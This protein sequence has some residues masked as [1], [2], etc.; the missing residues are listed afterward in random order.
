MSREG[1]G[2]GVM[3]LAGITFN[4]VGALLRAG[5]AA[6]SAAG[7]LSVSAR[8]LKDELVNGAKAKAEGEELTSEY[9]EIA[10]R[11]EPEA[12]RQ[13]SLMHQ[14]AAVWLLACSSAIFISLAISV[15]FGYLFAV[16]AIFP[17][18]ATYLM[19]ARRAWLSHIASSSADSALKFNEFLGKY[20][21]FGWA[22]RLFVAGD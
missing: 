20:G 6:R 1:K 14:Q 18:V 2:P 5:R 4:P 16:P 19:A 21:I 13:I 7:E 9:I 22:G 8:Y 10:A 11:V 15:A 3:S 17:C 12:W